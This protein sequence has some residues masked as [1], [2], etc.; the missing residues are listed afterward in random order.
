MDLGRTV[1]RMRQPVDRTPDFARFERALT[2]REP[3]PVPFGDLFADRETI[4]SFL[5]QRVGDHW[6]LA[7]EPGGRLTW[8]AI[9]DGLRFVDQ[10]I[11]FCLRTGWDY[12][13]SFSAIPFQGSMFQAA[14]NTSS[15]ARDGTR[16]WI[17]DNRGP[18][19]DWDDFERYPWPTNIRTINLIS[20]L[21]AKRVPEGMKVMVIPGGIFE[22]TT[23]LMGLVPFC[24]ALADQPALVDAVIEKV[25]DAVYAVVE[26][27]MGE[28]QVGGIF[29]GDDL[30][31]ASGTIVSPKVLRL[32][33]LPETKRIVDLVR[34]AGKLFVLHTCGDVYGI[35]DDL[36]DLGIH[37]KHSF[38]DKIRPV[39]DVY[40]RWGDQVA[41]VGGVDVHLLAS[42]S[43]TAVRRRTRDILDV[44][45]AGGGYVLGT[46]NSVTNYIPL[47]NYLA[48]LDEGH[49][50]NR[51]H[52]GTES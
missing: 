3:G 47:G 15:E 31:Y 5:N 14:V 41:L 38:E 23:W 49:R 51:E 40:R 7:S 27:L 24:Y 45:G 28:P 33:F 10:T 11:H 8:T 17:D 42:G 6:G 35:M 2:S 29:M 46:G 34:G 22:W 43:E 30:G 4:A 37:A 39:E 25:S 1:L 36:I 13:F 44:C 18:I 19:G 52:F 50:W 26:D 9:R 16:Y 21:M 12:A 48:M 32:K 20:R